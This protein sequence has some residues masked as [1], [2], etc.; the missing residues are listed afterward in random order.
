MTQIW[1]TLAVLDWTTQLFAEAEISS[2]RLEAQLLLSHVLQC[3]RMQLYT[4]FDKP[5][6]EL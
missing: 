6:G 2:A 5:L 4:G 1:T 3:T